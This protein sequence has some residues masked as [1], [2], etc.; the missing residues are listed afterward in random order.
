[1]NELAHF[2]RGRHVSET[3]HLFPFSKG[4]R[5]RQVLSPSEF[6]Q[7]WRELLWRLTVYPSIV[8]EAGLLAVTQL[9]HSAGW[10]SRTLLMVVAIPA[11][12][13]AVCPV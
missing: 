8:P 12:V 9:Y 10:P 2:I 4:R 7:G 11:T 13:S 1:V 3:S 5:Y 6:E